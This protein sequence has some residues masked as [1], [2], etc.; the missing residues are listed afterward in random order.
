[1]SIEKELIVENEQAIIGLYLD[2]I[3]IAIAGTNDRQ[4]MLENITLNFETELKGQILSWLELK[5][6]DKEIII[7]GHSRAGEQA[8]ELA[9]YLLKIGYKIK[10][11]VTFGST[12]LANV[13][14]H[15]GKYKHLR[16]KNGADIVPSYPTL[17][18]RI[19]SR[20]SW[21]NHGKTLHVNKPSF[22]VGLFNV[23]DK[24]EDHN[25]NDYRESALK[26]IDFVN[27]KWLEFLLNK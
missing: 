1:M 24:V 26:E 19:F 15:R 7:T 6:D 13:N 16:V 14:D 17:I 20:K 3:V 27:K 5:G 8:Q 22:F 2:S 4:D 18:Q 12:M 10:F 25:L 21:G 9:L 11:V 23:F